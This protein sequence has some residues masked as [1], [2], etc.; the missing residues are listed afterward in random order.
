METG[1]G[2]VTDPQGK[3]PFQDH[4]VLTKG[5]IRIAA[6]PYQLPQEVYVTREETRAVHPHVSRQHER[7]MT[8]SASKVYNYKLTNNCFLWCTSLHVFFNVNLFF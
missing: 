2:I 6:L 4:S 5:S 1:R 7:V 8:F 3:Q